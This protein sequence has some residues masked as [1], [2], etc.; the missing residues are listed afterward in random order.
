MKDI[1]YWDKNFESCKYSD[2]LIERLLFL[3]NKVKQPIDIREVKKGIYYARKYHGKQMRQ[4]GDP[5]YSHPIAVTIMVA[6]FVAKEVPK[7]F[8]SRILQAALLHDTI[9]DTEL[10]KDMI[11]SIFDEEVARHVEGLTRIKPCGKISSAK[12]LILLIKQK[13]YDTAL[14]KLFDRIH[15]LQTLEAKSPEKA[16]KIIK[17]TLKSFLVLSEILEIPSVSE[18]IYA[19]CY[20]NNLKFNIN[21][22][23]NKIINFDSSPFAQNKLLP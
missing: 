16:H 6:E 2:K 13:R 4:S 17:E 15:N 19:E 18:L 20:K 11:S 23:F 14:I 1:E 5:Y 22:T 3:N 7:L 12:S 10:T 9:E 8:T 21:A